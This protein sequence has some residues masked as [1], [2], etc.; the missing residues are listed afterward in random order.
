MCFVFTP[1][2]SVHRATRHQLA[3]LP[4][5]ISP[6]SDVAKF[7]SYLSSR[8]LPASLSESED[9]LKGSPSLA[10]DVSQDVFQ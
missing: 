8:M 5:I 6:R 1:V 3:K 4:K 9:H 10:A 2:V 7:I